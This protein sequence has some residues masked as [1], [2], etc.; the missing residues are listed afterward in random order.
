[1]KKFIKSSLL[2]AALF[3]TPLISCYKEVKSETDDKKTQTENIA[4]TGV[5]LDLETKSIEVGE[6]FTL[7]ATI[8]PENATNKDVTWSSSNPDVATVD[9]N[10]KVKTVSVGNAEITITTKDGNKTAVCKVNVWGL[11]IRAKN[12]ES[13][14]FDLTSYKSL[15]LE[16][17]IYKK[18]GTVTEEWADL[19]YNIAKPDDPDNTGNYLG[20][21]L[22]NDKSSINLFF[23]ASIDSG[24][25]E[26]VDGQNVPIYSPF[27]GSIKLP[28]DNKIRDISEL[29]SSNYVQKV[30]T[31][32]ETN[33]QGEEVDVEEKDEDGNLIYEDDTSN[34]VVR[35]IVVA[36]FWVT[37]SSGKKEFVVKDVKTNALFSLRTTEA[38]QTNQL[39]NGVFEKGDEILIEVDSAKVSDAN[40]SPVHG[41]VRYTSTSVNKMIL[42]SKDNNYK[43]NLSEA[44]VVSTKSQL[45]GLFGT[46]E[47][48]LNN[49]NKLFTIPA[50]SKQ[51]FNVD[52]GTTTPNYN[53]W[54]G[55]GYTSD[56]RENY[57]DFGMSYNFV[58]PS[59]SSVE[60]R[61]VTT[62][63]NTSLVFG[64]KD[65]LY[66]K[67]YETILNDSH[68]SSLPYF[69]TKNN[70]NMYTYTYTNESGEEVS[71]Q[72]AAVLDRY[73]NNND[74]LT[75]DKNITFMY[76]GY[77]SDYTA[78]N[79]YLTQIVV[80]LDSD[81]VR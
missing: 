34:I 18:D 17:R 68:Y 46:V 13:P 45:E 63:N 67:V 52:S 50:N 71:E 66:K 61:F 54:I 40:V 78:S 49:L 30:K 6:E 7:K 74:F 32:K 72:R 3:S 8:A 10:G 23:Y 58:K 41:R 53:S 27:L 42:L 14:K 4:V 64:S 12:V 75:T 19:N 1:M 79:S 43:I 38:T 57:T 35:G 65:G 76:T 81:W 20:A 51:L 15:P 31:H 5:T 28:V 39:F 44:T 80:I 69:S 48:R 2:F 33:D 55:I 60:S 29:S 70:G 77:S 59:G 11:E 36:P 16:Y 24:E 73:S 47:K 37:G 26:V 22:S 9:S 56:S 25:V 21:T 62:A